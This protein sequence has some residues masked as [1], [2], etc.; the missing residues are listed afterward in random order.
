MVRQESWRRSVHNT[1]ILVVKEV[2]NTNMLVVKEVT[3]CVSHMN[4]SCWC[5]TLVSTE[6]GRM[7]GCL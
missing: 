7:C 3:P 4:L 2:D 5:V 6:E 1:N